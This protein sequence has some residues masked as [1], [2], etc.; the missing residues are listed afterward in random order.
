VSQQERTASTVREPGQR[1]GA[2]RLRALEHVA[3]AREMVHALKLLRLQKA[4]A[5]EDALDQIR[6]AVGA[7]AAELER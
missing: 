1:I 6:K 5:A 4:E 7:L 3:A 2:A